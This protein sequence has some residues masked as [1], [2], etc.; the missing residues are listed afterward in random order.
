MLIG[1]IGH[2]C[3]GKN[4]VAKILENKGFPVIDVDKLGHEA[5][6]IRKNDIVEHFGTSILCDNGNIDRRLLGKKVFGNREELSALEKIV[7]PEAERLILTWIQNQ[8]G[9]PCIINAALLHKT[10]IFMQLDFILL[11]KAP[12]IVRFL[13]AK[14][15]DRLSWKE[16]IKRFNSQKKFH[17]QYS[18]KKVDIYNVYNRGCL[19]LFGQNLERQ[20]DKIFS[21]KGL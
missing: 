10:S 13:R 5:I 4:Y 1:L 7:H 11:V 14:K 18:Q 16:L 21:S 19:N 8:K 12:I 2:Y 15:R 17:Y 3:A 9:K 6:E 20:I